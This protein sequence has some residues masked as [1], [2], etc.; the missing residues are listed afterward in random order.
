MDLNLFPLN[1]DLDHVM[2]DTQSEDE[3][4]LLPGEFTAQ[5]NELGLK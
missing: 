5:L 2:S 4:D 3:H 1:A